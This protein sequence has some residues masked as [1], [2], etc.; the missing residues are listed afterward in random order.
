MLSH[1]VAVQIWSEPN[2]WRLHTQ[3]STFQEKI[4][5]NND[6]VTLTMSVYTKLGVKPYLYLITDVS[7][8]EEVSH[9]VGVFSHCATPSVAS[10]IY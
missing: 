5:W 4:I 10:F 2:Y 8:H 7:L 6:C 9:H 1:S 3:F